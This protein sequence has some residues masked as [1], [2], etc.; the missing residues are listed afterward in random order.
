MGTSE[1]LFDSSHGRAP[2]EH[3]TLDLAPG[4][5]RTLESVSRVH[6]KRDETG[7]AVA[8]TY[9]RAEYMAGRR[10]DSDTYWFRW[11]AIRDVV[12]LTKTGRMIY[13]RFVDGR[14]PGGAVMVSRIE[15]DNAGIVV[16]GR[17]G[18]I[19]VDERFAEAVRGYLGEPKPFEVAYPLARHYP[20]LSPG[21]DPAFRSCFEDVDDVRVLVARLYGKRAV[22]KSLVKAV[23]G[24]DLCHLYLSWCLRGRHIPVDWHVDYLRA[25]PREPHVG[26]WSS[27][28]L[29]GLR[30]H[31][32]HLGATSVRR[33]MRG[34]APSRH[35]LD[36][37]ARMRPSGTVTDV[38]TWK[39]LHDRAA[40]ADRVIRRHELELAQA[41]RRTVARRGISRRDPVYEQAAKAVAGSTG[42]GVRVEVAETPET[43]LGWGE[44]MGHCIAAYAGDMQNRSALLLGFFDPSGRLV[45]NASLAVRT[46]GTVLQ[47]LLGKHNRTLPQAM[48]DDFTRHLS[49]AGV[50]VDQPWVG[51]PRAVA[52]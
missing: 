40:T 28:Q 46:D 21:W 49:S 16:H 38:R 45:A 14:V 2:R 18:R 15:D 39:D 3:Q 24:A 4:E 25:N 41:K 42:D 1:K 31:L 26:R 22:R 20:G 13:L 47:Q 11:S 51:Q 7:A 10:F 6:V 35:L 44:S 17:P 52:A 9:T 29:R 23:A 30:A 12:R 5:R 8:V 32:R 43:L 27:G 34:E 19:A 48:V 33:L 50:A 37:V 36:D